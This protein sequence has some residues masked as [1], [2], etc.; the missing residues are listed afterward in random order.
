MSQAAHGQNVGRQ[1]RVESY[2]R[3]SGAQPVDSD[4]TVKQASDGLSPVAVE[5][6][7]NAIRQSLKAGVSKV[8]L[9]ISDQPT[10]EAIKNLLTPEELKKVQ[11][12][13]EEHP[14][15]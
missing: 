1:E 10:I 5:Q 12:G 6:E 14:V 7:A 2:S 9:D 4:G 13:S 15:A 3:W 11:F 8:R